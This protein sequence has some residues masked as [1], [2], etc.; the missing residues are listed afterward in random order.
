[1]SADVE[2][3]AVWLDVDDDVRRRLA[4]MLSPDERAETE[5]FRGAR[6]RGRF[7]VAH[8]ALRAVLARH[9]RRDPREVAVVR[10][11]D[12]KL[13]LAAEEVRFN[14]SHSGGLAVVA[15]TSDH[16]VG[17]DVERVRPDF[18]ALSVADRFFSADE[19]IALRAVDDRQRACAFFE[20]WTRKEAYLKAVGVGIANGLDDSPRGDCAVLPLHVASGYAAAI[21]VQRCERREPCSVTLRMA[22][23]DLAMAT[24][25]VVSRPVRAR[26]I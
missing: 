10:A 9:L 13:R 15:V 21:A 23:L 5:R 24:P 18:P 25:R 8:G 14:L 19:R 26:T 3:W 7:V 17:I 16:E 2:V 22:T 4:T 6:L 20:L 11:P 12:S 1:V